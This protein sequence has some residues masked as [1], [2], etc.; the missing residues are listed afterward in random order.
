MY[1]MKPNLSKDKQSKVDENVGEQST[2]EIFNLK[3]E[4]VLF[5]NTEKETLTLKDAWASASRKQK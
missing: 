2:K 3:D 1:I 5:K 4:G